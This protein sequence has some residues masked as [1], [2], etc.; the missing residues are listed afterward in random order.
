MSSAFTT[1]SCA[2]WDAFAN[3]L[4]GN[5]P[6]M[7]LAWGSVPSMIDGVPQ[8][9][10]MPLRVAS[11]ASVREDI[12][13]AAIMPP[14]IDSPGFVTLRFRHLAGV[15]G[16][17]DD[18]P[19]LARAYAV[20]HGAAHPEMRHGLGGDH[21]GDVVDVDLVEQVGV[22]ADRRVD[23]HIGASG[24]A[25]IAAA[26]AFSPRSGLRPLIPT[27]AAPS[28]AKRIAVPRPT[29]AVPPVTSTRAFDRGTGVRIGAAVMAGLRSMLLSHIST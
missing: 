23:K 26:R 5:S 21:A 19:R 27:K 25:S 28:R 11:I 1:P 13:V 12:I 8:L 15:R 9:T 18:H 16:D 4:P 6:D 22:G 29:P 3:S 10:R 17:V 24:T 20:D 2:I 7:T 14:M